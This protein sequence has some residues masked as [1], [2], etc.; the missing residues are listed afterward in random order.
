M[1]PFHIR[2][3]SNNVSRDTLSRHLLHPVAQRLNSPLR[4]N[5]SF[6]PVLVQLQ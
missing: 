3:L 2:S 1:E 5:Q 6:L 4:M